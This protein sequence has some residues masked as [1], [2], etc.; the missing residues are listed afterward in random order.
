MMIT[1]MLAAACTWCSVFC[2]D[3]AI[4]EDRFHGFV[5]FPSVQKPIPLDELVYEL[6]HHESH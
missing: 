4:Q 6:A 1:D 5:V 2:Y 3:F